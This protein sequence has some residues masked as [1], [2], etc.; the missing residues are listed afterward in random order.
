[1][2]EVEKSVKRPHWEPRH[3]WE[4]RVKFVEDNMADHGLDKA[5]LLS[6][7]WGNMKFMGCRYP[8]GTERLVSNYPVPPLEELRARRKA[9]E[10]LK[11]VQSCDE[12]SPV[13]PKRLKLED[14]ASD[15]SSLISSIRSQSESKSQDCVFIPKYDEKLSKTV[16]RVVQTVAN[17]ICLCKE[18]IGDKST[19]ERAVKMLQKYA[20]SRGSPF[21]F[22]FKEDV[23][24]QA[25][26]PANGYKCT[27]FINGEPIVDKM[28]AEKDQS[29]CAVSAEI[30]KMAN[31][32]QEACG[33][34]ACPNLAQHANMQPQQRDDYYGG[35][36]SGYQ[37][38]DRNGGGTYDNHHRGRGN[39]HYNSDYPSPNEHNNRSR[40]N[41]SEYFMPPRGKRGRGYSRGGGGG[42]GYQY[43]G[44]QRYY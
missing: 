6:I 10:S 21:S 22:D 18:C 43:G 13:S 12:D 8:Q 29:K 37:A 25:F 3:E 28:T 42:N 2:V 44:G 16:P 30:L 41:S 7:V 23:V 14:T 35:S 27:L 11:R 36:S 5:V 26:A 24:P 33:K 32:W 19:K 39:P 15:V 1:M 20:D 40:Y 9:K 38:Y 4:S 34:P 31:D 17:A